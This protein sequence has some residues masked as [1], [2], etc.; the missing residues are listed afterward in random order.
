MPNIYTIIRRLEEHIYVNW[1]VDLGASPIIISSVAKVDF[2][3]VIVNHFN[4]LNSYSII[5]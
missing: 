1:I 4:Y 3:R 5:I 2:I